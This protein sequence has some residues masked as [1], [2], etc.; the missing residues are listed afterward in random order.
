MC[1]KFK[2]VAELIILCRVDLV[3]YTERIRKPNLLVCVIII[4]IFSIV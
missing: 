3:K 1:V 2:L 4:N